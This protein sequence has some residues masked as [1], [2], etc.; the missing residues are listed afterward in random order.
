MTCE[1][2]ALPTVLVAAVLLALSA[3]CNKTTTTTPTA[4]Q[5]TETKN[6]TVA[7][8]GQDSKSFTVNYTYSSTDAQLTVKSLTSA[9]TGAALNITIGAGFG[10]IQFD[11][12]C[13]RSTQ[14]TNQAAVVGQPYSTLG[15]APF[16]PGNYCVSVFDAGTVTADIGPVNYTVEIVHY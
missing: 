11:G 5:V 16:G 9:A 1:F 13:G 4:T 6:G 3:G 8:G 10:T 2:R 12:S 7:P 14:F 15:F